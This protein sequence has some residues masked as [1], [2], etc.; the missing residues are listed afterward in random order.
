MS[1]MWHHPILVGFIV[2]MV[3]L[4]IDSTCGGPGRRR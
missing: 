1:E 2:F 4:T 3:C